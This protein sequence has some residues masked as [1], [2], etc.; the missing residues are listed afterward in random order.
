[1]KR[2]AKKRRAAGETNVYAEEELRP[3]PTTKEI[4]MTMARPFIMF[5]TEVGFIPN[6]RPWK[7]LT[8]LSADCPLSFPA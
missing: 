3:K 1:M 6:M 8:F 7:R 5:A 2:I 4:L